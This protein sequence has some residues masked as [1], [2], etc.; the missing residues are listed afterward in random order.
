M[1]GKRTFVKQEVN[2]ILERRDTLDR[3]DQIVTSSLQD[4]A[5]L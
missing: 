4:I 3:N 2:L 1:H 5:S